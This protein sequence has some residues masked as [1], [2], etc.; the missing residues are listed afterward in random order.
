MAL[1]V[2]CAFVLV[3]IAGAARVENTADGQGA[4]AA[5]AVEASN[6]SNE[7]LAEEQSGGCPGGK[8]A[9][10]NFVCF[11]LPSVLR[12]GV[13]VCGMA[14]PTRRQNKFC[15]G[16]DASEVIPALLTKAILLANQWHID[17]G[18]ETSEE[19]TKDMALYSF[20]DDLLPKIQWQAEAFGV[21]VIK[22][23]SLIV[24]D[25]TPPRAAQLQSFS[26]SV[27]NSS[28][29]RIL[30]HCAGG[31]GR[32]P[33]FFL[34]LRGRASIGSHPSFLKWVEAE[35]MALQMDFNCDALELSLH[36]RDGY[37]GQKWER[38]SHWDEW[39]WRDVLQEVFQ[40]WQANGGK[41]E[42]KLPG[43]AALKAL[44]DR[45][46]EAKQKC[47]EATSGPRAGLHVA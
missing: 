10:K 34:A 30:A 7:E 18:L 24:P 23:Q 3:Q 44:W 38:L 1:T 22:D 27:I 40:F 47:M 20:D 9:P 4:H 36:K 26:D 33:T 46:V 8:W 6:S 13:T 5:S 2:V 35:V 28:S 14:R 32:T 31:T 19:S 16:P 42:D 21:T 17:H 39:S 11:P 43:D 41:G 45:L 12:E 29:T 25:W 15:K 37:W